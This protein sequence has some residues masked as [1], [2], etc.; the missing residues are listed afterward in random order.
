MV[1]PERFTDGRLPMSPMSGLFTLESRWQRWLDVEAALARAEAEVGIVPREA[2]E[3]IADAASLDRLDLARVRADMA[4]SSH[5]LMPL[6]AELAKVAGESAGGW[7][8]WGCH[9][10]KHHPDRR[11][12]RT[13][14]SAPRNAQ[15]AR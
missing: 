14:R 1:S 15:D 6:I 10:A 2:A 7:V 4:A 3:A 8:H 11:R 12:S 9:D 5:P 13:T